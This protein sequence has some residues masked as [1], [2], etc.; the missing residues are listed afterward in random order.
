MDKLFKS[1]SQVDGT[2]TRKAGGTGLGLVISKQLSEVMGGNITVESIEGI[3]STFTLTLSFEHGSEV[4]QLRNQN[5]KTKETSSNYSILIAEDDQVNQL[6]V[7]RMLEDKGH[8]VRIAQNGAEAV[9]MYKNGNFDLILMDIHMPIMDGIEATKRIREL[10]GNSKYI[11]IVALT[12]YALIGD[13]EKFLSNSMNEYITK[14]L[15]M[16][17]LFKTISKVMS[18]TI[19]KRVHFKVNENGSVELINMDNAPKINQNNDDLNKLELLVHELMNTIQVSD[20]EAIEIL[21]NKIKVLSNDMELNE[22]KTAAFRAELAAR[23]GN[24]DETINY[25]IKIYEEFKIVEKSIIL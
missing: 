17:I 4:K 12:A 23:R 2:F 22:I 11:P 21:I 18:S 20:L 19:D 5:K 3:G 6:V 9:E 16:E 15:D 1:F 10:G 14:P 24:I 25:S 8:S 7:K 13:R